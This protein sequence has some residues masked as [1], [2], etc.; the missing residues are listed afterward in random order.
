MGEYESFLSE[1]E[2]FK[3]RKEE[4]LDRLLLQAGLYKARREEGRS[5]SSLLDEI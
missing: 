3:S 1:L 4:A 2:A 5:L